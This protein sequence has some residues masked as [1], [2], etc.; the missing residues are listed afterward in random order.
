MYYIIREKIDDRGNKLIP[1][2]CEMANY[3]SEALYLLTNVCKVEIR[4]EW[5]TSE[6]ENK[7][8]DI[9]DLSQVSEPLIDGVL[10][11]RVVNTPHILY[12]YQRKTKI[13]KGMVWGETTTSEFK[14]IQIYYLIEY[15]NPKSKIVADSNN[16][17]YPIKK[18]NSCIDMT[19]IINE[20]K[21]HKLFIKNS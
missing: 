13:V 16:E 14:L 5:G 1:E 15:D 4:N 11:Y 19:S 7:V 21:K 6:S 8:I 10:I 20:L 3:I 12:L 2:I 18:S 9:N 17:N